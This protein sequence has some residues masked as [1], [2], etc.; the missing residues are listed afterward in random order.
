MAKKHGPIF[1]YFVP[2]L[3]IIVIISQFFLVKTTNLSPWKGGGFGMYSE[4]HYFYHD[5]YISDLNISLDSLAKI[6]SKFANHLI[7][8]KRMPN[9][10]NFKKMAEYVSKYS[11]NDT[12]NIQV[13]RPKIEARTNTYSREVKKE[14]QFIKRQV[15]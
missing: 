5:V 13:W 2:M 7:S 9:S 15:N 1:N 8:L 11:H 14:Y 4:V 10:T 12:I 3:A 6:D